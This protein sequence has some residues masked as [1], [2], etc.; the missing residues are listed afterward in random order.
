MPSSHTLP[1]PGAVECSRPA[2]HVVSGARWAACALA[3]WA[4]D[5]EGRPLEGGHFFPESAPPA[6][7]E[8]LSD[9]F[10]SAPAASRRH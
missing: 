1:D 2:R 4:D 7:A 9:F 10:R 6:T 3:C 5:V 8:A